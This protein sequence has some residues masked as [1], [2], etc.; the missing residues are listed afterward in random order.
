VSPSH[1][2]SVST[3]CADSVICPLS[4]RIA[5]PIGRIHANS[6]TLT[7]GRKPPVPME[8]IVKFS[9]PSDHDNPYCGSA[10]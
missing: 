4:A 6:F 10:A 1:D 9:G 7:C 8:T 2:I 3:S 5:I